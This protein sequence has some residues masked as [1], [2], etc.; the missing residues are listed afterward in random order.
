[1]DKLSEKSPSDSSVKPKRTPL[2]GGKRSRRKHSRKAA[3][4]RWQTKDSNQNIGSSKHGQAEVPRPENQNAEAGQQNPCTARRKLELMRR[5]LDV[6]DANIDTDKQRCFAELQTLQSLFSAVACSEC[7]RPN[8]GSLEVAF[9]DKM[10]YSRQIRLVCQV[11]MH[12][13]STYL[14]PHI[15]SHLFLFSSSDIQSFSA[16][17]SFLVLLLVLFSSIYIK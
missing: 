11:C 12:S 9:G 7:G 1:M 6:A 16:G 8:A 17:L 4:A 2:G 13:F 14:L 15:F 10:G 3:Q 5:H